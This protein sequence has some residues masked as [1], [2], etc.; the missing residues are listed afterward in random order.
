MRHYRFFI[1]LVALTGCLSALSAE[2][3]R[4]NFDFDWQ[5][6]LGE[7][8]AAQAVQ[9]PHDW[10]V[11]LDF[12]RS[13]GAASGYLPGGIGYYSKT[14]RVPSS[15]RGRR[16]SL[17]FDGVYHKATISLNGQQIDYHRYGYTSFETDLTPYLRYGADNTIEVKVDHSEESRWYTGSGIYR[18]VWLQ[19]T[20]P[21]HVKMWGT[22]ITTPQVSE[23][24][25]DVRCVTTV[26]N[27]SAA[28]GKVEVLQRLVDAGGKP[29]K[30]GGKT[31]L[32]RNSVSLGA[33]ESKDV[34][35]TFTIDNP[36]IWSIATPHLYRLETVLKRGGKVIDRYT[37]RFGVRSF[38]FDSEQGFLLNGE[39]VK[40]KGMCLHQDAGCLGVAVPD[41]AYERRLTILKE[42]GVNAI[43]CSHNPPSP[44]FLDY[45]DSLGFVVIDEAFDKWKSGYYEQFFDEC[46]KQ[47][48]GDMIIRD[49]NHPSIVLW[50]IGNELAE[51]RLKDDTGVNRAAM[52]RD[53]VHELEPTRPTMLALAPIYEDKFAGVTDVV[54]Y[55][56]SELSYIEDRKHHPERIGLISE[57][58]P[59]Y[60]GLRPYESRDYSERNPWNYVMENDFI[61]GS[62]MWAGADYIGESM[63]WPSKGWPAA[64]F[65]MCMDEKPRAT[66]FRAVWNEEPVLRMAVVDYSIDED[67]G[68]DHWQSPPMVHDWTFP[69]TDD[70]VLP[71]HTASNCDEVVLID[72]RGKK[73]GPRRPA[74]YLNQAIVWNQP[75]RPGT[76]VA[77]GYRDGVEVCRDSIRT[78]AAKASAYS[79]TPD[80][81]TLRADG[82]DLS[83]ISLQ[84][85]DSDGIPVRID[86]R[87]VSVR[88]EGEGRLRGI[89]SGEMRRELRFDSSILPTY[90]GRCS[91]V[92]QSSRTAG[93]IRVAVSVDGLPEQTVELKTLEL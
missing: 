45:C 64:P 86:D 32:A 19:V 83:Y 11:T 55:N 71:I 67:P 49:R 29:L 91:I 42:F 48:I 23:A 46:W 79:L 15:Y 52:L 37:T 43:R 93:P 57:S 76:V 24:S 12:D 53:F 10:S 74:D 59:Y 17:V 72:P 2:R 41:R 62:F 92:V 39:R 88:V 31:Y 38:R 58:Y 68:K 13:A 6:R 70:R 75:Y 78:S 89:D 47:D 20:D 7:Q 77:I 18:H 1:T 50:S 28:A 35:Q 40:M 82:Q 25:A 9:L 90:F 36:A 22:Y 16:V 84:L 27:D 51:A 3:I 69:Y 33:G 66:Y 34:E 73:Y 30:A 14:F 56:Y 26:S 54:G 21:V 61:C 60:S 63:G 44:E 80:R 65:D 5:F 4:Q 8:G 85:L 87:K 81:R